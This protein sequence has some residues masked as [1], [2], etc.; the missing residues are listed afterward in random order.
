M[1][2]RIHKLDQLDLLASSPAFNLFFAIDRGVRIEKA[3]VVNQTGQVVP[4]SES[5]NDFVLMLPDASR[6]VP[7]DAGI[8]NMRTLSIR[9]DIDIKCLAG[10]IVFF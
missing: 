2:V 8:Q 10:R 9:H 6:Q 7:R 1:P 5:G 3:L 4:A